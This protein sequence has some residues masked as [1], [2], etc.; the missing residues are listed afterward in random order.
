MKKNGSLLFACDSSAH[1]FVAVDLVADPVW[2]SHEQDL[3]W[4]GPS[5]V[6]EDQRIQKCHGNSLQRQ[7]DKG[8]QL[9]S[10]IKGHFVLALQQLQL[11]W[12]F[13]W[14]K[15]IWAPNSRRWSG[16]VLHNLLI[17]GQVIWGI[18]LGLG[19]QT[20]VAILR[21]FTIWSR[22]YGVPCGKHISTVG[23]TYC[24]IFQ[25]AISKPRCSHPVIW[26]PQV[27]TSKPKR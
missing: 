7:H 9:S 20:L 23:S 12:D 3:N 1:V 19:E 16:W 15:G 18:E 13:G 24:F 4:H 21:W 26:T 5:V 8:N 22:F 17:Y 2:S 27:R 25:A 11:H 6:F 10:S 14:L